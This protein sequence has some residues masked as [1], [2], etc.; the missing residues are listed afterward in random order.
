MTKTEAVPHKLQKIGTGERLWGQW[1]CG[2]IEGQKGWCWFGT[3]EMPKG[4][5]AKL[6]AAFAAHVEMA[7]NDPESMLNCAYRS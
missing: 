6:R 5:L 3:Y 7:A 4:R 1:T 2:Q